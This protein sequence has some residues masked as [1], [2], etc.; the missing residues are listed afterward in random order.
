MKLDVLDRALAARL[1][2]LDPKHGGALRLFNGFLE[3]GPDGTQFLVAEVYARTLLLHNHAEPPSG[4]HSLILAAQSLYLER[5]P[6]LSAVVVKARYDHSA[7]ERRG[8]VTY[9]E[10]PDT[11]LTEHGV[12]YA[13]DLRMHQD[14][15]F[16][17][18]T[19]ELRAW[20]KAHTAGQTVLN[21]FAYT[22]SLGVAALAG[23][24]ARVVQ[25]DRS[26]TFLQLAKESY[27]L[28]GLRIAPGDFQSA[29][30]FN[31]VARLKRAGALFDTVVLDPPFFSETQQGRI[32][33]LSESGR[34]INKVRPLVADEGRLVALNNALFVSG[35]E[36]L[37]TLET[38][39]ADGYLA[40]ES[41]VPV[42]PDC[43]GYPETRT[44]AAPADPAP[45]NHSTKIAIL[46]VRRKSAGYKPRAEGDT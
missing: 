38:L 39:C 29:D 11:R 2:Q 4:I 8:R 17:L 27:T 23:G 35:A 22:G 30:F 20:L 13:L 34:L 5:L 26:R 3:G 1:S 45:F 33:L 6:W 43:A 40:L 41:F 21:A 10:R 15:S 14:A 9:G 36:Y 18:D 32:N 44:R 31:V 7:E 12:R 37:H 28:N 16:Y 46:R 42:P 19:R 25:T 24:A